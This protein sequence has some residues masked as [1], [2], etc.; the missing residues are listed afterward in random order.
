MASSKM[1]SLYR[2]LICPS[3]NYYL[4]PSPN[5]MFFGIWGGCHE[6]TG[7]A[8]STTTPSKFSPGSG[9]FI[10]NRSSASTRMEEI[11][12]S[13]YHLWLAGTITHGAASVLVLL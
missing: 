6:V 4:F 9:D 5:S 1:E 8:Y 10:F 2:A 3:I 7:G 13:R 12:R 11:T